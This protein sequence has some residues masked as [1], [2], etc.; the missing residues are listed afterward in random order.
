MFDHEQMSDHVITLS[1]AAAD[2]GELTSR[3]LL[4]VHV[5]D[6]NDN[7]PQFLKANNFTVEEVKSS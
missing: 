4:V 2:S 6:A 1:I 5:L 7:R 3:A